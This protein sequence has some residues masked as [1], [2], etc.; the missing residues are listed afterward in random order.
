VV[1]GIVFFKS[2]S[3]FLIPFKTNV[4]ARIP[5]ICSLQSWKIKRDAIA[6]AR[7]VLGYPPEVS[8]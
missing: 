1:L 7:H 4:P 8:A 2:A 6:F 3:P 5:I